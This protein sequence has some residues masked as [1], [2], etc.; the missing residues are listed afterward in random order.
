[1][2]L[3]NLFLKAAELFHNVVWMKIPYPSY[4]V[5]MD[6]PRLLSVSRQLALCISFILITFHL[7]F[8]TVWLISLSIIFTDEKSVPSLPGMPSFPGVPGLP[9]R[10]SAPCKHQNSMFG[11]IEGL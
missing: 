4:D 7:P 10:P 1:M 2:T 11:A 9:S 8:C 6:G 3:V 5:A